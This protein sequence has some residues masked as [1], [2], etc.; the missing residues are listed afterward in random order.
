MY[1]EAGTKTS[2]RHYTII[3]LT[4][5]TIIFTATVN[6]INKDI[7]SKNILGFGINKDLYT[8]NAT[9]NIYNINTGEKV[10]DVSEN[11]VVPVSLN[12]KYFVGEENGSKLSDPVSIYISSYDGNEKYYITNN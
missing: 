11:F 1:I 3:D 7:I 5:G 6:D 4:S 10:L 2:D 9:G 12:D 8:Y